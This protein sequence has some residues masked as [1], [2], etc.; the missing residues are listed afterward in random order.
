MKKLFFLIL[1]CSLALAACSTKT[2]PTQKAHRSVEPTPARIKAPRSRH[3]IMDI[4]LRCEALEILILGTPGWRRQPH[5][6]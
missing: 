6:W 1:V 2:S 4:Q 3:L 5:A